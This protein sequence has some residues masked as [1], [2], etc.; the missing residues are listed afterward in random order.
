[1]AKKILG[2]PLLALCGALLACAPALEQSVDAGPGDAGLSD[3][4]VCTGEPIAGDVDVLSAQDLQILQGVPSVGGYLYI[5][6]PALTEITGLGCLGEVSG[7]LVI[8]GNSALTSLQGL[9]SIDRVGG[10]L[11]LENNDS[12]VDLRGLEGVDSLGYHLEVLTNAALESLDGLE[13]LTHMDGVMH[14]Y[15]NPSLRSLRGLAVLRDV[16]MGMHIREN[17]RLPTCEAQAI[18]DQLTEA[19]WDG[20][21]QS[22]IAGND[23]GGTCE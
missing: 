15:G 4:L 17:P 16:G 1:M 7:N 18:W 6:A 5:Y 11:Y 13:S 23:D 3:A 14:I 10:K 9:A 12:L 21:E 2:L 22:A 20:Q 8:A 19:G